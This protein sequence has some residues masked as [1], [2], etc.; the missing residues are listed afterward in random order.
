VRELIGSG[1]PATKHIG[2]DPLKRTHSL[3]MTN[4]S[5]KSVENLC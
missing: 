3:K 1:H 2:R 4:A 5:L